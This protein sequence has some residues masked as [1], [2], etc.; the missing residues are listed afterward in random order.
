MPRHRSSTK[1]SVPTMD[2]CG[3]FS[4]GSGKCVRGSSSTK[5][6]T[7]SP[8][9]RSWVYATTNTAATTTRQKVHDDYYLNERVCRCVVQSLSSEHTYFQTATNDN[10]HGPQGEKTNNGGNENDV[11]EATMDTAPAGE[12]KEEEEDGGNED[13]FKVSMFATFLI[14]G[15]VV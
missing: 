10:S 7:S 9:M 5:K 3:Y 8:T 4:S 2:I 14:M 1:S 15:R 13:V 12:E 11:E 6:S